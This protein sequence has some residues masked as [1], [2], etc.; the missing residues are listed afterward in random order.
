MQKSKSLPD[1]ALRITTYRD[2]AQHASAF[3][4]G[5]LSFLMVLGPAGVGKSFTVRQAVGDQACWIG[6]NASPFRIYCQAYAYRDLPIV[7]DDVDGLYAEPAGIRLLKC[8]CQTD[9]VKTVYWQTDAR[10]LK[11]EG[12]P[13]SYTTTGNVALIGNVWRSLNPNVAALEDRGHIISFEPTPLEVHRQAATWFWDQEVFDFVAGV[14]HLLERPSLRIYVLA[15]EKKL[16]GLD[17]RCFILGRCL[18]G[19]ALE[20]ARLKAEPSFL[21]EKERVNA[22]IAMGAGSRSSYFANAA[23]LHPTGPVP[24]IKLTNTQRPSASD[25]DVLPMRRR[26]HK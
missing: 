7:L 3:A 26:R 21:S 8:L 18:S 16:A 22:F 25:A 24:V 15:H 23:K 12:I 11:E 9:P 6:G 20:V 5:K 13:R 1:S 14:L 17:W 2:L 19:A 10:S 4:E